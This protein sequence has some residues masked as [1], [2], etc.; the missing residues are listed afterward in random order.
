MNLT[1]GRIT[2]IVNNFINEEIN[3]ISLV[4]DSLQLFNVWNFSSRD[5]SKGLDFEGAI[6]AQIVEN[7]LYYYTEP[8]D[9]LRELL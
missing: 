5:K 6:P 8:F 2:Q 3:K 7:L 9:I 1:H 4:P